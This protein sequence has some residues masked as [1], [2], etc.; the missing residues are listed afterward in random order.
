MKSVT[1]TQAIKA[2]LN[3]MTHQDLA[4]LYEY[5]MECQVNVAQ[6][7]GEKIEG[8]FKGVKWHGY[9]NGIQTWKSFRIPYNAAVEPTYDDSEMTYD[10]GAH[11]EG[12][13]MTGW[14]WERKVSKW[15]AFDFDAITGHSDSHTK[16]LTGEELKKIQDICFE[17]PW[18][19]V[20][21]STSGKG[22]HLYVF[23]DN[24]PTANH[25][26]HAGLA[27]A[28]LAKMSSL[29]G[30][31]FQSKVD[32]CGGNMW[33]W[34]RKMRGT[35]GLKILKQGG[36]LLDIP[37]N[38]R[39]HIRV[40]RGTNK[41]LTT[42][43]DI[44]SLQDVQSKFD[45]LAGQRT[46]VKLD[47]EHLRLIKF[48]NEN[49]LFHWWDA[50]HH[51]L[52][53]HTMHLKNAHKELSLKGIFETE[54]KG[55]TTH[56][57][58]LFPMRRGSWS[59]RRYSPGCKEHP[60]WD[61]DGAGWTRCYLNTE[62]TLASAANAHG[63]LED[64][65]GGYHFNSG[66]AAT[67]A[68]NALG[69]N[70]VI[71]PKYGQRPTQVKL[72]K[73]G[74]LVIEFPVDNQTDYPSEL[75]GWLR[76]GNKWVKMFAAP[77]ANS[78]EN[79]SDNYDDLV[80]HI[81]TDQGEDAGWVISS[82]GRWND[83]PLTHVRAALSSMNIKK[84]EIEGIIG[85]SVMKPWTLVTR[86][87]ES[88][89]PGDR[90]WNRRAPQFRYVPTVGDVLN[91]PTYWSILT[92]I[93]TS[94]ND[95]ISRDPWCKKNGVKS[96]ADYLKIWIASMIQY[97]TEPLPYLFIYGENQE[98]GKSTLH[99]SL[100]L[101]F[102]PG[103]K[104]VDQ[105]LQNPNGFNGE[106]EGAI[107]CVIEETDLNKNRT[108]QNRMKDWVT[109]RKFSL[110]ALYRNPVMIINMMHF[111]QTANYRTECPP[112]DEADTR[113]TMIH[114]K[115]RPKDQIPKRILLKQLE[116]EAAD[117]LGA[118][119]SL[120]IPESDSRLRVP[121][122]HT[123]DKSSA[124]KVQ[125][126]PLRDFIDEQCFKAP[127]QCIK[128]SEFYERFIAWLEPS[129]R[130]NWSSKQKVSQAM[131]DWVVK[132]RLSSDANWYWGNISFTECMNPNAK[133]YV[134]V[135]DKLVLQEVVNAQ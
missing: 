50:D 93:G 36:K 18:V 13:G 100:E 77:K 114:V 46:R 23:V 85:S 52:V 97:P 32:I 73:D 8:E 87:F 54:T 67:N 105:A 34:H 57:C 70:V 33:V 5:G 12:I 95:T 123:A 35:E 51:M 65:S 92:H 26:E 130:L 103:Y 94:L 90:V 133:P 132:G 113:I 124:A 66:E 110:R 4:A 115:E 75:E 49:G 7:N 37:P 59:V 79:D 44:E 22:L 91:Y 10:I 61:Q 76:K 27:R 20:R 42:P 3:A 78:A 45:I 21:Y 19:T 48:L 86:P 68:A 82:D 120:E 41:K 17:I 104:R 71:P 72:H 101:L 63:G 56:N 128:L 99:E 31:D 62:P 88:E 117:F 29:T 126:N 55:S 107:L 74:R 119:V 84:P 53:T 96:G 69:A 25:T 83:E 81:I 15:V 40:V 111:I 122:I 30:Y 1:K 14:D 108:A 2:F 98:T 60:S 80:R 106:L 131:P 9:S 38:W 121:V 109:A 102:S 24:V 129:E 47:E 135:N 28:I 89:Y 134:V 118:L 16:K 43:T 116:K 39:D 127:G 6:D 58:F 64:P 11:A 125:R 112:F